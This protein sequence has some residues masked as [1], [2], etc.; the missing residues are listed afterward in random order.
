MQSEC[1][2]AAIV[3]SVRS[4][5]ARFRHDLTTGTALLSRRNLGM[6]LETPRASLDAS[7]AQLQPAAPPEDTGIILAYMADDSSYVWAL[8]SA[9]ELS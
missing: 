7:A 5:D 2:E 1:L 6:G 4:H 9:K 8:K 3:P